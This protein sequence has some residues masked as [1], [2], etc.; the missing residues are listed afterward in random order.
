MTPSRSVVSLER[1]GPGVS[2]SVIFPFSVSIGLALEFLLS[3]VLVGVLLGG[4]L[5]N[6]VSGSQS[7]ECQDDKFHS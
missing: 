4:F 7:N 6:G 2:G 1:A 3:D 5:L